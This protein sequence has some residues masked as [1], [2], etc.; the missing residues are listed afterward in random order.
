MLSLSECACCTFCF[1]EAADV[2]YESKSP[3]EQLEARIAQLTNE[4]EELLTKWQCN[5]E[6]LKRANERKNSALSC[7]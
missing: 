4:K 7:V 5:E 6:E 3:Q 1:V 2:E